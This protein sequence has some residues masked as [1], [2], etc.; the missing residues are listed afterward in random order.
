M[1]YKPE[2]L[3]RAGDFLSRD[4]FIDPPLDPGKDDGQL[5]LDVVET[6]PDVEPFQVKVK[7]YLLGKPI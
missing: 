5:A 4:A 6:E 1:T 3:N 2:V 7:R